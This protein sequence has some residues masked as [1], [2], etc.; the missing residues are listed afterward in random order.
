[1]KK[2]FLTTTTLLISFNA[3]A[4]TSD[5]QC[6]NMEKAHRKAT[7]ARLQPSISSETNSSLQN[8]LENIEKGMIFRHCDLSEVGKEATNVNVRIEASLFKCPDQTVTK[9]LVV[10]TEKSLIEA[11]HKFGGFRAAAEKQ[12]HKLAEKLTAD[13][14]NDSSCQ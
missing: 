6:N 4:Y 2:F 11:D 14:Q 5:L 8:I 12:A 13:L 9:Q 1:M 10:E 3:F 7:A